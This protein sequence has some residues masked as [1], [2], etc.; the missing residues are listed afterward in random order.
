MVAR[1]LGNPV[2]YELSRY[3]SFPG[4]LTRAYEVVDSTRQVLAS[5]LVG[6]WR[7]DG[8]GVPDSFL[9]LCRWPDLETRER[10]HGKLLDNPDWKDRSGKVLSDSEHWIVAPSA[11]S[12]DQLGMLD[13]DEVYE[14]RFQAIVNG[15]QPMA[16][17]TFWEITAPEIE[18]AGGRVAGQFDLVLGPNRPVFVTILAWPDHAALHEGWRAMDRSPGV[19]GQREAE[20]DAVGRPYFERPVQWVMKSMRQP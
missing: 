7:P 9:G 4:A 17:R 12:P 13:G 2:L 10:V 19:V 15:S 3:R 11:G 1:S 14:F 5:H 8:G 16:G 18:A 20:I 6:L